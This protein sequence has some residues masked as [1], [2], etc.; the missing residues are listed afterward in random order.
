MPPVKV[1]DLDKDVVLSCKEPPETWQLNGDPDPMVELVPAGTEL[2]VVGLDLP[3]TGNYTCWAHGRLL[4]TTFLAM[5][6]TPG[7]LIHRL[8]GAWGL[9]MVGPCLQRPGGLGCHLGLRGLGEAEQVSE[10]GG[11][12]AATGG[13]L[14]LRRISGSGAGGV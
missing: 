7:R 3:A 10:A 2:T 14:E 12:R 6:S 8:S 1:G 4:D 11:S 13:C 9:G 5:R